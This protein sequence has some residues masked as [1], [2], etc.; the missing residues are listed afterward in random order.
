MADH[1]ELLQTLHHYA[2]L[3]EHRWLAGVINWI[4]DLGGRID[5]LE[6][7]NERLRIALHDAIRRPMGVTPD[8]AL[9][10]Y[11][12][13]LA[14]DRES[15]RRLQAGLPSIWGHVHDVQEPRLCAPY[16]QQPSF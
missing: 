14:E 8:T 16:S 1:T 3:R 15:V 13:R 6:A 2:G 11:D 4:Y 9:E 7:E 5:E 10:F 12:Q